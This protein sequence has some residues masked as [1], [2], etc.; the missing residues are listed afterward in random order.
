M[1]SG[2]VRVRTLPQLNQ[3][4]P[5]VPAP[6]VIILYRTKVTNIFYVIL[7]D[8]ISGTEKKIQ[9]VKIQFS[10]GSDFINSPINRDDKNLGFGKI[11]YLFVKIIFQ[12]Y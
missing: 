10:G 7:T 12:P 4:G 1:K 3:R 9:L 8:R 11:H 6:L 2:D 5:G